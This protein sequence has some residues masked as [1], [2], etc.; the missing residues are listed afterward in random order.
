MKVAPGIRK[1]DK[2]NHREPHWFSF[3]HSDMYGIL[4][5]KREESP[6]KVDRCH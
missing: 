4:E 5:E 3:V 1:N 2:E 6:L